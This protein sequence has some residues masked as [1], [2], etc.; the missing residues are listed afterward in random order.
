M[1]KKTIGK[2]LIILLPILG[3]I[4]LVTAVYKSSE[5]QPYTVKEIPASVIE[6]TETTITPKSKW[7]ADE[8]YQQTV[9]HIIQIEKNLNSLNLNENELIFPSVNL[10]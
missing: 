5:R 2:F 8:E 10:E 6:K 9:N 1:F 3:I 7:T 4:L